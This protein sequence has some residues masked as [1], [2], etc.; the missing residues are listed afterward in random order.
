MDFLWKLFSVEGWV[1]RRQCGAWDDTTLLL[2]I[3]SDLLIFACYVA[4]PAALWATRNN[5]RPA[6]RTWLFIVFIL[7][8]GVTHLD[9]VIVFWWPAYRLFG[10]VK[11]VCAGA[12]LL[13]VMHYFSSAGRERGRRY[14]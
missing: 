10:V 4:I 6:V 14:E 13:T 7:T 2:H 8:C 12:S 1:P 9:D 3:V 11:A 5:P